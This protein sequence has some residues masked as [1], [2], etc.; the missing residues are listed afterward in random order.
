MKPIPEFKAGSFDGYSPSHIR[1]VSVNCLVLSMINFVIVLALEFSASSSS[2]L[3]IL[4]VITKYLKIELHEE[5][6]EKS[7]LSYN[8][9]LNEIIFRLF[10]FDPK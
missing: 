10:K 4:I 1:I 5:F 8:V 2:E 6:S 9:V 7:K 3:L